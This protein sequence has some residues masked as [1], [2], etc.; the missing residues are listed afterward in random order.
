M[1]KMQISCPNCRQP[2]VAD[3]EQVFDV[4]SDPAA[5]QRLLSGNVNMISCPN[6]GYQGVAPTMIVYHDPEKELLMTFVPP[7][8]G[9]ARDEQERRLG[10]LINQVVTNLP[11]EKRKAYILQPQASLTYQ[12]LIERIL[13]GEGIT[14][15]MIEAQQVRLRLLQRLLAATSEETLEE[16]AR[17]ED[18]LI[19]MEFFGL[20]RNLIESS[21]M[22]GDTEASEKLVELQ[23]KLMEFTTF[24]SQIKSQTEEIQAAITDLREAGEQLTRE[25]LLELVLKAP[26]EARLGAL[27]SLAR[28]GMD[29]EFF[30]LLS[31]RIDRA[32]GDGRTRLLNLREQLLELTNEYDQQVKERSIQAQQLLEKVIES[33]DIEQSLNQVLPAVDEF[34]VS[35]LDNAM[36]TARSAG[37]LDKLGKYQQVADLLEQ[38]SQ[39]PAEIQ[40]IEEMLAV[41]DGENRNQVWREMLEENHEIVTPE[42]TSTIASISAQAQSQDNDGLAQ[43]L[44]DLNKQVLRYSMQRNLG[45]SV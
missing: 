30:K 7:E 37:D 13:E 45:G 39:K 15:E 10:S 9:L 38:Y 2:V 20:L 14:K 11:Q 31:E 3:I 17:Q 35:A 32:R 16:I 4:A 43:K 24:G 12:G 42:F 29:Y 6:C 41:P 34:F 18:E 25:K 26:S 28:P 27:V 5:K 44:K 1:P 23:G 40:L 19:D 22:G 33:S 8:L 36:E 21:A